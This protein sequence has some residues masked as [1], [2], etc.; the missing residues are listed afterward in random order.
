M[1]GDCYPPDFF[2][3]VIGVDDEGKR[4]LRGPR[5]HHGLGGTCPNSMEVQD[6]SVPSTSK[7]EEGIRHDVSKLK[8]EVVS[9]TGRPPA[10]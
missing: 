9:W 1:S 2:H 8:N 10:E 7:D 3:G 5:P 6:S 4:R